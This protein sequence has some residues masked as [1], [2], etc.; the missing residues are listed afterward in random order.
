MHRIHFRDLWQGHFH[1]KAKETDGNGIREPDTAPEEESGRIAAQYRT[2]RKETISMA[3]AL[4]AVIAFAGCAL[5]LVFINSYVKRQSD[6]QEQTAMLSSRLDEIHEYMQA[7]EEEDVQTPSAGG[8]TV[9]NSAAVSGEAET[10]RMQKLGSAVEDLQKT[11]TQYSTSEAAQDSSVNEGMQNVLSDLDKLKSDLASQ[12]QLL[13]SMEDLNRLITQ[14]KNSGQEQYED[15]TEQLGS[16]QARMQTAYSESQQKTQDLINSTAEGLTG[17]IEKAQKNIEAVDG[18]VSTARN[19]IA[20]LSSLTRDLDS[21]H[22]QAMQ[23]NLASLT[24]DLDAID[25]QVDGVYEQ[26]QSALQDVQTQM[27]GSI[28]DA[29]SQMEGQM[30]ELKRQQEEGT[31]DI[32]AVISRLDS[33]QLESSSQSDSIS[34][35]Q[36]SL[37][38][39]TQSLHEQQG[40]MAENITALQQRSETLAQQ[41]EKI[42]QALKELQTQQTGGTSSEPSTS[43]EETVVEETP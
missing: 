40:R 19:D 22:R 33:V 11:L 27:Q 7:A 34:R 35:L 16:V 5:M 12:S 6:L 15:L 20:S 18:S 31:E 25:T 43:E 2:R 32:E 30:E 4:T 37:D 36:S 23:Q 39:Q 24:A 26:M 29:Q 41:Q 9:K 10:N 17:G 8:S 1:V 14:L 21:A 42:L 3:F 28:A 13:Q 38:T